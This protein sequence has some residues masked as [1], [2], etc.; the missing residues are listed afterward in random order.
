MTST[1]QG[2]ATVY[3]IAGQARGKTLPRYP[4]PHTPAGRKSRTSKTRVQS[5]NVNVAPHRV[6]VSTFSNDY[7][8]VDATF[9]KVLYH[10]SLKKRH[11]TVLTR[12]LHRNIFQ[13]DY[14]RAGRAMGM[15][16]RIEHNGHPMDL[17]I[18]NRWSLGAEILLC[19]EAHSAAI[20]SS[21]DNSYLE[22]MDAHSPVPLGHA[23]EAGL[24]RAKDYYDRLLLH[25]P[26][27]KYSSRHAIEMKFCMVM[28]GLWIYS[29]QARYKSSIQHFNNPTQNSVEISNGNHC[30]RQGGSKAIVATLPNLGNV[31]AAAIALRDTKEVV[32]RLDELL[33]SPPHS[34]DPSLWRMQGMLF[35]WISHLTVDSFT[36]SQQS[37]LEKVSTTQ[38]REEQDNWQE[39][40]EALKRAEVSFQKASMLGA[41]T[42]FTN[43]Q[44]TQK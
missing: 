30:S 16:L 44:E 10:S 19:C 24:N 39:C 12:L 21:K 29:I 40:E 14:L 4:F 20:A 26:C 2:E 6:A 42:K 1:E 18:Y 41:T 22:E 17:R 11:V 23:G 8:A 9:P 13:K 33:L 43:D 15:L 38:N 5:R 3:H 7:A 31:Q 28:F 35:M 25:Y 32:A 34:D 37:T 36:F 27:R